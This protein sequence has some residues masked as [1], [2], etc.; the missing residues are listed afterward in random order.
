PCFRERFT[1][2]GPELDGVSAQPARPIVRGDGERRRDADA[3]D[4]ERTP[5]DAVVLRDQVPA[6]PVGILTFAH[7][8]QPTRRLVEMHGGFRLRGAID[9][10]AAAAGREA[11]RSSAAA[12]ARS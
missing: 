7:H 9:R 4:A 8:V 10:A 2:L 5:G 12:T 11:A 6:L 1:L 3:V